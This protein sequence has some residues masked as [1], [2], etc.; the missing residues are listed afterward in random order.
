MAVPELAGLITP[1]LQIIGTLFSSLFNEGVSGTLQQNLTVYYDITLNVDTTLAKINEAE[2][3][4]ELVGH[5][6]EAM[7]ERTIR[8]REGIG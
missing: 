1:I 5:V 3:W 8:S 2:F 4:H 7:E 6:I